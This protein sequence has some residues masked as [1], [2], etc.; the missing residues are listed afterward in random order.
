MDIHAPH[1]VH[2]AHIPTP[3]IGGDELPGSGA[4]MRPALAKILAEKTRQAGTNVK[5]G[6]TFSKLENSE[7][8]VVVTFS[9]GT[10]AN[11]DLV[12]GSDGLLSQVRK[13]VFPNAQP[14]EYIG[15]GVWR[16]VLPRLPE[17]NNTM[18]WVSQHLKVGVNPM[19]ADSMYLFLTENRV[20]NDF[21]EPSTFLSG[22]KELLK[23]F[24]APLVQQMASMLNE[25]SLIQ[26]RPLE[27]VLMPA[28][29]Y[30]N[31]IVLIGDAVHA[32]TPHLAS[33]ACIG[34][35]DAL[36]L[37]E[38]LATKHTAELAL[39]SFQKR[40]YERCKMVVENSGRLAQIEIEGGNKEEHTQIMRSSLQALA[41]P[42]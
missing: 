41:Q 20:N 3:P 13:A 42:I 4:I 6:I 19:S 39:A 10:S 32:T 21:I 27:R 40:R 1:G 23:A 11:Y 17:V 34:I 14:P 7:N 18:M 30:K 37:A 26:Y 28:P 33:G 31:R 8:G 12:V 38:E 36:V 5:L 22:L 15:Q 24:P 35:E 9:D 2:L 29:W 25:T 16:A